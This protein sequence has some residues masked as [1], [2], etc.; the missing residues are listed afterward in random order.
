MEQPLGR[1]VGNAI[2][3]IESIEFLKGNMT[4]D[5]KEL[6]Y[7]MAAL[8]LTQLGL[9]NT[10]EE[11]YSKVSDAI[12]SGRGL[13]Y[14]KKLI[15]SQSG[16][17]DV[18]ENYRLFPQP[19]YAFQVKAPQDGFVWNIDAYKTAYACKILGAGREKK[20][21][22]IDYSAGI[23]LNKIC[24]EPV[25]QGEVVATLYANDADKLEAAQKHMEEAFSFSYEQRDRG[26]LIY[27]I[28]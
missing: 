25:K 6:T 16:N 17:P 23:Y 18:I 4:P 10:K 15:I 13:E 1:A 8:T 12:T 7:E 5:I 14:F 9:A 22:Q 20:T 2:E 21:D 19:N 11:A 26:S 27:K 28:L 24:A 3:V